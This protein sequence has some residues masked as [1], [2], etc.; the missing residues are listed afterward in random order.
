MNE[1][2]MR[3]SQQVAEQEPE[4]KKVSRIKRWAGKFGIFVKIFFKK[5]IKVFVLL[6]FAY[7]VLFDVYLCN[8]DHVFTT[9]DGLLSI[10]SRCAAGSSQTL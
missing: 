7:F 3:F 1:E 8:G 4:P 5:V 9:N 2:E 10:A 6:V